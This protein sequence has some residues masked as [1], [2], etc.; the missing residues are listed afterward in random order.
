MGM[1]V[2]LLVDRS[3]KRDGEVILPDGCETE[4][5]SNGRLHFN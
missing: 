4:D 1:F 3:E 5:E 2:Y